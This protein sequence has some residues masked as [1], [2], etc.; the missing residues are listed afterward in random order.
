MSYSKLLIPTFNQLLACIAK[1]E[2]ETKFAKSKL[3]TLIRYSTEPELVE[4]LAE[5]ANEE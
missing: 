2:E 4:A 5:S 1:I 3:D